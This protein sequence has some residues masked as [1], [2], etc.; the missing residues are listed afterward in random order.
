VP[1]TVVGLTLC[2]FDPG[3]IIAPAHA[4]AL[5]GRADPAA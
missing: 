2:G 1:V 4:G 3:V 5:P